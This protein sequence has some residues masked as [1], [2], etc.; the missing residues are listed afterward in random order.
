MK[1]IRIYRNPHCAKCARYART[2]KF[3]DWFDRVEVSTATPATGPLGLGE[4]VVRELRS[5]RVLGGADALELIFREI[6]IY[7]PLRPLLKIPVLRAKAD[8]QMS[9]CE[10]GAAC[11][12]PSKRS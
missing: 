9:G 10:G 8:R 6:P 1:R 7:A 5:G 2:H 11:E 4:V 3:F 12:L